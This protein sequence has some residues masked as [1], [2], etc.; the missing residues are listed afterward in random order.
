M[1]GRRAAALL[2][3]LAAAAA[4]PASAAADALGSIDACIAR[5]DVD[6]DIGFERIAARCPELARHLQESD[7]AA[8]LPEQWQDDYNNLSARNLAALHMIVARELALRTRGPTPE[9]ALVRPILADLAARNPEHRGWWERLRSWLRTLFAPEPKSRA[10]WFERLLGRAS[11]S[12]ALIELVAYATLL[13]VVLLAGYIVVNEWRASG[14]RRHRTGRTGANAQIHPE[15]TRLLSWH[16][17]ESALP[18]DKP[19]VLLELLAARLTEARRL[20]AAA[21]LTVRELTRAAQLADAA[22]R[23]RLGE[24]ASAAERLRFSREA[25]TPEG[26]ARVLERGR[27]LLERLGESVAARRPYGGR[28]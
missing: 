26:V 19:R 21:A 22:D 23:E 1:Q 11:L 8:W 27:E 2:F 14:V 13:L 7:W 15:Q 18:A 17:V 12:Q 28:A 4:V 3:A 6:S 5:L 9:V 20:P 25:P 16:D 10:N 24:V